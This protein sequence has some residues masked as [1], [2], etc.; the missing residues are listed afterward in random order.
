MRDEAY[1][2]A[3]I[4]V[5]ETSSLAVD[6]D[7]GMFRGGETKPVGWDMTRF[8]ISAYAILSIA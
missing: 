5:I 2:P 4:R 8:D 7:T 3:D 6:L 1:I